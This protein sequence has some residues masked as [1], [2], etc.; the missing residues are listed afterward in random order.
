M[1]ANNLNHY[2]RLS[3]RRDF[4]TRTGSGLAGIALAHMLQTDGRAATTASSCLGPCPG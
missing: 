4:F 2:Q 3:S 1:I